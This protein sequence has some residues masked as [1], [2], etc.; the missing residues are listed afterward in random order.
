MAACLLFLG[1]WFAGIPTLQMGQWLSQGP[2]A[3]SSTIINENRTKP[4]QPISD[5]NTSSPDA[6]TQVSSRPGDQ[7]RSTCV[8]RDS[9]PKLSSEEQAGAIICEDISQGSTP[10]PSASPTKSQRLSQALAEL[11]DQLDRGELSWDELKE[12]LEQL[13]QEATTP[14]LQEALQQAAK[15]NTTEQLQR[16]LDEALSQLQDQLSEQQQASDSATATRDGRDG[17]Q[18]N[19]SQQNNGT[20]GTED[21]SPQQ[22]AQQG[23]DSTSANQQTTQATGTGPQGQD[24]DQDGQSPAEQAS[25]SEQGGKDSE[26]TA[27][28]QNSSS[29]SQS[30]SAQGAESQAQQMSPSGDAAGQEPGQEIRDSSATPSVPLSEKLF[31]HGGLLPRDP[32][33]LER[34][35][36]RGIPVDLSGLQADGTPSLRLNLQ[37]VE[38]LLQ[39]RDLPPELRNLVRAYFLAI[40]GGR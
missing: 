1:L 12:Q 36:T 34:M 27:G 11:K 31:I 10:T 19:S 14:Q 7:P 21:G 8:D 39:S 37:R 30:P 40:A 24:N 28:A 13:A 23:E 9:I 5:S 20:P 2:E 6:R 25:N 4:E 15:A 17:A 35:L 3:T 33:L 38:A 16:Q 18:G 22:T 32:N 26:S 29:G